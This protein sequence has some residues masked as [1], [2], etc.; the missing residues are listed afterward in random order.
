MII[1]SRYFDGMAKQTYDEQIRQVRQQ[2]EADNRLL[3]HHQLHLGLYA[4]VAKQVNASASFVSLVAA[5]KR[6]NEKIRRALLTEIR[7]IER[8]K[9]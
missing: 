3:N 7:R 6:H 9:A 2:F 4:R 5:G 8:I 1:A